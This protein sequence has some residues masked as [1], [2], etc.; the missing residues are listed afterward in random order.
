MPSTSVRHPCFKEN[1]W[2]C[3]SSW[4]LSNLLLERKGKKLSIGRIRI[5][6][7]RGI[8]SKGFTDLTNV[9]EPLL[10]LALH[11]TR[12]I[13]TMPQC[14]SSIF[15]DEFM[16]RPKNAQADRNNK[17]C[18]YPAQLRLTNP[19]WSCLVDLFSSAEMSTTWPGSSTSWSRGTFAS[20][21]KLEGPSMDPVS[22]ASFYLSLKLSSVGKKKINR[23][24]HRWAASI[25]VF[26]KPV[27]KL[28]AIWP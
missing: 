16:S 20:K 6:D 24:Y 4:D 12:Y 28:I 13:L 5:Q 7:L 18:H 9:L 11:S 22:A 1:H 2:C 25:N 17:C 15:H 27:P 10:N 26:W 19:A 21:S 14:S 8:W 3:I 23:P